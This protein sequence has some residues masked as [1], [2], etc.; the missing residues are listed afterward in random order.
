[1]KF[2]YGSMAALCKNRLLLD[3]IIQ[4]IE[5]TQIHKTLADLDSRTVWLGA[6]ISTWS[7]Q[8]N[9][10]TIS[11]VLNSGTQARSSRGCGRVPSSWRSYGVL[12]EHHSYLNAWG[13]ELLMCTKMLRS[14]ITCVTAHRTPYSHSNGPWPHS[15]SSPTAH[16]A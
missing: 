10:T 16:A 6:A 8:E 11:G 5:L 1:M 12:P 14:I 13:R 3:I 15:L 2:H 4:L 7:H 9:D